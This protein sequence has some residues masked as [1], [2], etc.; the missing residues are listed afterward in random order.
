MQ[1]TDTLHILW[2]DKSNFNG[3]VFIQLYL[4]YFW[5]LAYRRVKAPIS[6]QFQITN[7]RFC[8]FSE[9]KIFFSSSF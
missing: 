1:K 9:D 8:G 4:E 3:L 6:G 7:F 5:C 2:L